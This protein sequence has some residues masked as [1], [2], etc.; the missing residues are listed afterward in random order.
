MSESI[1]V[2]GAGVAG[3]SAGCY[4][5]M[6]GYKTQIFELHDKPGGL[7]TAWKRKGFTFDG[8]IDWL[9]GSQEGTAFNRIW[10]E[11]GA[12][13]GRQFVDHDIHISVEDED[14][15]AFNIYTNID[16]LERHMKALSPADSS[17]IEAFC[18]GARRMT[19]MSE[20]MGDMGK[21]GLL[22]R[23]KMGAKML[24]LM[25]TFRKYGKV[26]TREFAN[27]F[28]D[29]FLQRAFAAAF[30]IA[31]FPVIAVMM[32]LAW[33]HQRDAG[34]P[35][36]GSLEFARAIEARYLGLGG[37]LHYNSR[38]E[39]ILVEDDTAVGVRLTDGTEHRADVVIS[40]ADGHATIFDMLGGQYV[41]DTIRG[42]YEELP[43]FPS[44]V[45]VSLG[46]A[47]DLTGLPQIVNFPLDRPVTI[48]GE[49]EER[50]AFRHF[51]YDPTAAPEG[52]STVVVMFMA[53]YD[54]WAPLVEDRERYE[55]EKKDVAIKTIDALETR[56]PG[57]ADQIE[58]VDVSTPVT[59]KRYTN[60]WQGSMEGWLITTETIDMVFG[61]GMKRTLPG[62][63]NFYMVGQWVQPGGG[64]PPA[65]ESGR[66]VI[67][68]ICKQDGKKF[69][70]TTT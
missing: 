59:V 55:A 9:V 35:I 60:N 6:N 61:R 19:K 56:L 42:Y 21:S 69:Q 11:L 13:Q 65:A 3:L 17:L 10:R 15:R 57:I 32:M 30:D 28:Q 4:G 31:G 62:L 38:V 14:G 23:L 63:E 22:A 53:D 47:R 49:E 8:C 48:G 64:L 41:D 67:G 20:V 43:L 16:R 66:K 44:W 46:V 68:T 24:P 25:G 1:I 26:S 70:A 51:C 29:P 54:Y 2:I 12:V 39:E 45:Q 40:A 27:W 7:C 52:K 58:V 18:D 33:H 50:I 36:G 34:Y 37:E 5:Q